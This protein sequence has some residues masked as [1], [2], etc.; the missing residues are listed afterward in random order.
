MIDDYYLTLG[1]DQDATAAEIRSAYRQQALKHHPDRGGSNEQMVRVNL[2]FEILSDP[3]S[4]RR[5]DEIRAGNASPETFSKAEQ[6]T[7]QARTRSNSYE[8]N[9]ENFEKVLDVLSSDFTNA[10]YGK[11]KIMGHEIGTVTGSATGP[12][13]M[14]VGGIL[15]AVAF[16]WIFSN[17]VLV[18]KIDNAFYLSKMFFVCVIGG[19]GG[20]IAV[21]ELISKSLNKPNRPLAKTRTGSVGSEKCITN[22]KSC[23][24]K[25]RYPSGVKEIQLTCP[26]CKTRWTEKLLGNDKA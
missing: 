7:A 25:L 24:Q 10:K 16:Y 12:V 1:I 17:N 4:R 5:Y 21:H 8:R 20:G 2:A 19:I 14:L 3:D 23:G 9:W 18:W 22:C 6:D 13:F 11:K 26:K 15:G